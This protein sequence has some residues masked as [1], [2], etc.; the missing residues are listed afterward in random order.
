MIKNTFPI[1][2]FIILE[3]IYINLWTNSLN[4]KNTFFVHLNKN[5]LLPFTQILKNESFLNNSSLIESSFLDM[6]L[7]LKNYNN[8]FN[9]NG[10]L[11]YKIFIFSLKLKIFIL[12]INNSNVKIYKSIDKIFLNSNWLERESSEMYNLKFEYKDDTRNLLLEY[13]RKEGVMLKIFHIEGL[14]DIYY[15]FFEN[16]IITKKNVLIE[17]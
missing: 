7:N 1:Q 15:S 3:K 6:S 17:L 2:I 14:N 11:Y 16:Q 12:S 8:N 5:W 13:S 4:S 10:I 9:L